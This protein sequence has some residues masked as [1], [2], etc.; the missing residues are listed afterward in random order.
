VPEATLVTGTSG[1]VGLAV[2]EALVARGDTVVAFDRAPLPEEARSRLASLP[3]RIIPVEGDVR[4]RSDLANAFAAAP[5]GRVLHAAVITAGQERERRDAET[6]VSV[7][8]LGAIAVL[9]A[10]VAHRVRRLVYPSSVAVYGRPAEGDAAFTEDGTW[11]RPVLLYGITKLAAE[12][13]LA[14]LARAHGLS[15][16]AARLASLFGPWERDTGVRDT[17]SPHLS[18]IGCALAGREAVLNPPTRGDH[19]YVRDAARGLIGLL[20]SPALAH[21]LFNLGSGRATSVAEF[22]DALAARVRGFRWRL[23]RDGEEANVVTHV[24]FDRP[25]M[26]ISRL[27][28]ATGFAPRFDLD[29]AAADALAF[30]SA[31]PSA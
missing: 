16:A 7:N 14:R 2:A 12:Q 10:A 23:A 9:E 22:C 26:D 19:L 15:F 4:S 29:A 3:G 25:P 27:A 18:A 8:L 11:P 21:D 13:A 20:D 31:Q 1:F 28:A 17:L 30:F 6:I 5:V 24:P